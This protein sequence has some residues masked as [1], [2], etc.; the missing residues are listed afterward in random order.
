[1]SEPRGFFSTGNRSAKAGSPS[2]TRLFGWPWADICPPAVHSRRSPTTRVSPASVDPVRVRHSHQIV[3]DTRFGQPSA[4]LPRRM[5]ACADVRR[6]P[7]PPY[8]S[9]DKNSFQKAAD[10]SALILV[11]TNNILA[12]GSLRVFLCFA[13]RGSGT[14]RIPPARIRPQR[15]Y[16]SQR[17]K[18]PCA[19]YP[20]QLRLRS[21]LPR[22]FR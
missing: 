12:S 8:P 13:F 3:E 15:Q 14:P 20:A 19:D 10:G 4:G 1:V 5:R 6:D 9:S 17:G 22:D 16:D 18:R 2:K 21:A 7:P 11:L